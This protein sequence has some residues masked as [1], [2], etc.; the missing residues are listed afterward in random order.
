VE[1][2]LDGHLLALPRRR[3]RCLLGV[4]L[5]ELNRTVTVHRLADLL[6]DG[7]AP[8][9]ARRAIHSHV[10]RVRAVLA[11]AGDVTLT[12]VGG[13]YR[14]EGDPETVDAHRFRAMV[15][16]AAALVDADERLRRR[17]AAL[18]LW[19][20]RLLEDA[21]GPWLHDRLCAELEE[22][23]MVAVEDL[24]ADS[25]VLG[26]ERAVLPELAELSRQH[27][28]RERL[29]EVHMRAL[30]RAGRKGE[31]LE[32]FARTRTYLTDEL[33]LDPGPALREAQREVLRDTIPS[34]GPAGS[35]P[36]PRQLPPDVAGFTGREAHLEL[37]DALLPGDDVGAIPVVV[38]IAGPPGVGKTALAVH[39]AHRVADRFP[40]GQ[41]Y[42]NL[43]GFDASGPPMHPAAAVRIILDALHVPVHH[44]PP[45]PEARVGLYRT[46]LAQRRML[47]VLD[48]A[49]DTVQVRDL[50]P[51]S[52]GCAVV[53]TSRNRL[54]GLVASDGAH[55]VTLG[56]LGTE[57]SRRLLH[58]RLGA[59]RT[60]AEPAAADEI[61]ARCAGLPLALAIAA[62]RAAAH[63]DFP[64]GAVAAELDEAQGR[65]DALSDPDDHTGLRAVFSWSYSALGAPAAR[66]FR[67]L[68]LHPG[69]DVGAA[70]AAALNEIDMPRARRLLAELTT[71]HLIDEHAPGRY[72]M[73]D[74]LR[75]YATELAA[76]NDAPP[77]Q[78]AGRRR[79]LDH[80]LHTAHAAAMLINPQRHPIVMDPATPDG[81]SEPLG[82]ATDAMA[83]L[84]REHAV[85][86]AAIEQAHRTGFDAHAWRLAWTLVD[87]LRRQGHWHEWRHT[88]HVALDAGRRLDDPYAQG[89]AHRALASACSH[90]ERHDEAHAHLRRAL[91]LFGQHGDDLSEAHVQLDMGVVLGRQ[92]RYRQALD[93]AERATAGYTRTGSTA[94]RANA[95]NGI[96]WLHAQLGDYGR[97]VQ[98]CRE[99][100]ILQQKADDPMV[101]ST[102]DSLG[103]AHH[104]LGDQA[105]A[106][107]CYRRAL[108]LVRAQ[109]DRFREADVLSRL[110]DV[111]LAAEELAAA[112]GAWQNALDILQ[113]IDGPRADRVRA[114]LSQ[115]N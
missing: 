110:G 33:G 109:G 17:R 18:Q 112:R 76:S 4:L 77:D 45:S 93:H 85:L 101:A 100:L 5:L 64:L 114:K 32:L 95:L 86:L 52:A 30:H 99:A 47:L 94:A 92:G 58:R 70:A 82:D 68:A 98:Y 111:H 6:W 7:D 113:A 44:M 84:T 10:S 55:P 59:D 38:A 46:L 9:L 62:A 22:R 21:A 96:G 16:D 106:A 71:T 40:D 91:D 41:V 108:V 79:L 54:A 56:V 89:V 105:E 60:R 69:P 51:G 20:G 107:D 25:L 13:G 26:R 23:R 3:E 12:S 72:V 39:W 83:W 90:L 65:L 8:D 29:I 75:A 35:S 88:Q 78:R 36:V 67:H 103:Y 49:R 27:P 24:M 66:L 73:H 102:L 63:P 74:L 80:Y 2:E 50:L 104:R 11:P 115:V 28:G 48:N 97:A 87:F 37:L 81:V 19:R 34:S 31:A 57:E 61:A 42:V 1:V 15:D 53:V 43:R 14:L